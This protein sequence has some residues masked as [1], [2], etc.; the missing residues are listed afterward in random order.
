MTQEELKA[1]V[2]RLLDRVPSSVL[3]DVLEFLKA[4]RLKAES[5]QA[6]F[7]ALKTMLKSRAEVKKDL[8]EDLFEGLFN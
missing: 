3:P 7:S 2:Q 6:A 4:A 8:P 1:E 5:E